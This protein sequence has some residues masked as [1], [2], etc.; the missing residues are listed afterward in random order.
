MTACIQATETTLHVYTDGSALGNPG[1]GGWAYIITD[2]KGN[3]QHT[4]VGSENHT[5]NNQMELTAAIEAMKVLPADVPAVLYSDSQYVVKG[6]TEWRTSWEAK[7]WKGSQGKPIANMNLWQELYALH[8]SLALVSFQWVRGHAGNP[9]NET[10]DRLARAE[11]EKARLGVGPRRPMGVASQGRCEGQEATKKQ[12]II[13]SDV[14]SG[15]PLPDAGKRRIHPWSELQ[16]GDSFFVAG[17]KLPSLQVQ[18]SRKNQA[19]DR[20][21]TARAYTLE[22]QGGVMVWRTV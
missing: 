13:I 14:L 3:V 4:N 17:G 19:S 5:T 16:P 22:G 8:D 20:A 11:A 18:C 12:E 2:H 9:L 7:G 6:A 10:V 15:I 21:F 1:P